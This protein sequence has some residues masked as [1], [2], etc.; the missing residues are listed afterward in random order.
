MQSPRWTWLTLIAC[1]AAAGS[2]GAQVASEPAPESQP[3][4]RAWRIPPIAWSGSISYDLR[5]QRGGSEGSSMAHLLTGTLGLRTYVYQPWLAVVDGN[6]GLTHGWSR[7]SH[8]GFSGTG[9]FGTDASLHEAIRGREQFVTG[10][11]NVGVFPQSRFPFQFHLDRAD[12]R[13]NSGLAST[14]DFQT[15]SWGFSQR[16]RPL[17]GR[18]NM[19]GAYEHREQTGAE[20][21]ASQDSLTGDF[22]ASWKSNEASLGASHSR[23]RT[24]G[25]D[26][27]SRF[28]TMVGRHSYVPSTDLSVNSTANWTR[29]QEGVATAPSD[30][31][32]LQFSSVGMLRRGPKLSLTGSARALLLREELAGT[33]VDSGGVNL[34]ANYEFSPQLRLTANGGV[35]ATRSGDTASSVFTGA[36]GAAYQGESRQIA[37]AR[38]DWFTS[39]TLGGVVNQGSD[40]P[41]ERQVNLSLQLGHTISRTWKTGET[42]N[43]GFNAGQSLAWNDTRSNAR[44]NDHLTGGDQGFGASTTLL[45]TLG[46]TWQSAAD[47]RTVYARASYNDSLELQSRDRFQLLNAQLSGNLEFDTRRSLSGDLTLQ[48]TQQNSGLLLDGTSAGTITTTGASGEITYQHQRLFDVPRLRFISRLRLAQDVLKQPGTLL[49]LPDR[50]TRVWEN[51]LDWSVGRLDTQ[52]V[53]RLSQV[54]G[55]ARQSI[56]FRVQRSFGN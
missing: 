1:A 22:N 12:S 50:E 37:G 10:A 21:R 2:A 51:R 49:S 36:V 3:E 27:E 9:P 13:I 17:T 4:G 28:T 35:N 23:A 44:D 8:S 53:L 33:G 29:T 20:F 5:S 41:G 18:W 46:V 42:S 34:G 32:V 56:M 25:L 54:N 55:R 24:Q 16:Y 19:N 48:H 11:V 26:D 7:E 6:I 52:V 31:Q 14:F 47:G 30:L 39:G 40:N 45:N 15:T 38:Y 43:L